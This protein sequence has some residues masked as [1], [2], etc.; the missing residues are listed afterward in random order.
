MANSNT[1]SKCSHICHHA[2]KYLCAFL[3]HITHKLFQVSFGR[4]KRVSVTSCYSQH[5]RDRA[6]AISRCIAL[7]EQPL[8]G[9]VNP[10]RCWDPWTCLHTSHVFYNTVL[11]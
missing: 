8:H 2:Q 5:V 3:K 10:I 6:N 4:S 11:F 7:Y 9:T 1:F